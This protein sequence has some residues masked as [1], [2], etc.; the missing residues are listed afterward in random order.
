MNRLAPAG[1]GR[2]LITSGRAPDERMI[3]EWTTRHVSTRRRTY[4]RP[5]RRGLEP[6]RPPQ[7]RRST[8]S[9]SERSAQVQ[10]R[11]GCTCGRIPRS[12]CRRTRRSRSSHTNASNK[13]STGTSR[14]TSVSHLRRRSGEPR[15]LT[16]L[17]GR[18][19]APVETVVARMREV[20][21]A[22]RLIALLRDPIERA[23]SEYKLT[24]YRGLESRT[25]F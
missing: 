14:S 2:G 20:V 24:V 16:T 10:P 3:D 8:L 22:I 6:A 12:I 5:P 7:A 1:G 23:L 19:E 11:C 25:V 18:R 13:G 21:P 4:P 17:L 15:R 9:S